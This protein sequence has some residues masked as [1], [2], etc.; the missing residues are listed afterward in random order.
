LLGEPDVVLLVGGNFFREV[1]Y[2]SQ[3]P[4]PEETAV[5][6]IDAAPA[7]LARNFPV[8]V[9]LAASPKKALGELYA[10]MSAR[11]TQD[12]LAASE[13][14]RSEQAR[15]KAKPVFDIGHLV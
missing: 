2:T 4:W 3:S 13:T 12:F 7:A 6:Q 5:I 8:A 11:A 9:G 1:F 15:L 10:R 14:R